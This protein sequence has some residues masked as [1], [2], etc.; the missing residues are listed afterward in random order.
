MLIATSGLYFFEHLKVE[1]EKEV[2]ER[3]YKENLVDEV[4]TALLHTTLDSVE[5]TDAEG[6]T[7]TLHDMTIQSLVATDLSLK[8]AHPDDESP[9]DLEDRYA[10]DVF[11]IGFEGPYRFVRYVLGQLDLGAG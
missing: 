4:S 3:E 6:M 1:D 10:E 8:L 11:I 7:H 9:L 5:Y 2:L